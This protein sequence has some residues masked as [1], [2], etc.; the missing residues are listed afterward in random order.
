MLPRENVRLGAHVERVDFDAKKYVVSVS[1]VVFG[2]H[3][4]CGYGF[5]S[6]ISNM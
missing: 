1:E 3:F 2:F 5:Y 4:L 6:R